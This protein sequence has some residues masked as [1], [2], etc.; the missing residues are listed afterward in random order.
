M[1]EHVSVAMGS[2]M[3]NYKYANTNMQTHTC[4]QIPQH[5]YAIHIHIFIYKL[6]LTH[7]QNGHTYTH[8]TKSQDAIINVCFM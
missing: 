1:S 5:I 2:Q 3:L 6:F 8:P 7:K 4:T